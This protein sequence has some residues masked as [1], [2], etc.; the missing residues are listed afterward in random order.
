MYLPWSQRC[1]ELRKHLGHRIC[2]KG[3]QLQSIMPGVLPAALNI[4][5]RRRCWGGR[6]WIFLS[7]LRPCSHPE[8]WGNF[9]ITTAGFE[10]AALLRIIS[11]I[12]L[13]CLTLWPLVVNVGRL[14]AM[15][16]KS[17]HQW[18][19]IYTGI[20]QSGQLQDGLCMDWTGY[21]ENCFNF[22]TCFWHL[23]NQ[24]SFSAS[25]FLFVN[26]NFW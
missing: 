9:S 23:K 8:A 7:P 19:Q 2:C 6:G 26:G 13:R 14:H 18:L 24:A 11:K 21:L 17:C 1:N 10:L 25:V 20:N 22:H 4:C 5:C 3:F 12:Q 15:W 16:G